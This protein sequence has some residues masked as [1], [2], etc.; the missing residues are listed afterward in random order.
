[1]AH[2]DG[3]GPLLGRRFTVTCG[4]PHHLETGA[5]A[6]GPGRADSG[7]RRPARD[8]VPALL[9]RHGHSDRIAHGENPPTHVR[10]TA[11][12]MR[13]WISRTSVYCLPAALDS[14]AEPSR[15]ASRRRAW[16]TSRSP[17]IGCTT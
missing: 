17:G 8:P 15:A 5:I 12:T 9:H 3:W 10:A 14:W 13:R 2:G 11:F 7:N 6:E 16:G 4:D 1:M